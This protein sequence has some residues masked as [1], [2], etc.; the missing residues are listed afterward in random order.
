MATFFGGTYT[1]LITPF[2]AANQ[3]DWPALERLIDHQIAAGITGLV[4][5]GT[6][7]ESPTLTHQEHCEILAPFG[8]DC[9]RPLP[10]DSRHRF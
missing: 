3:I 8:G 5:V 6:T 10:G 1:A 7:G 4:F 9:Q 2:T